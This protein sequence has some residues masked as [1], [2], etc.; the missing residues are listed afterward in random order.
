MR[1][2]RLSMIG[3]GG[4][5]ARRVY[6]TL[7]RY[8]DTAGFLLDGDV[9]AFMRANRRFWRSHGNFTGGNRVI[10]AEGR[11]TSMYKTLTY[12]AAAAALAAA[13]DAQV[14]Y[15]F[16]HSHQ[17]YDP[18]ARLLPSFSACMCL[19]VGE[20]VRSCDGE[21]DVAVDELYRSLRAP[22]DILNLRYKGVPVGEQI[23]DEILFN[24]QMASVWSVD[25]KARRAIRKALETHEAV[26]GLME[27]Y[28]IRAGVFTHTTESY[29]GIAARTLLQQQ[30]PV[31]HSFGG[32]GAFRRYN[33]LL[34]EG[35]GRLKAPGYVP[36]RLFQTLMS[37]HG[38]TLTRRAEAFMVGWNADIDSPGDAATAEK[39]V[40]TRPESFCRDVGLDPQRPCVF[41]MLHAL[42]DDPHIHEQTIFDDYYGWLMQTLEIA[43]DVTTVNWIFKEHPFIELYPD[44]IERH[45]LFRLVNHDH[46]LYLDENASF[47]S[48]SLPHIA[49]AI[50]TCAGTAALEYT[51]QG[52]P[53][54]LPVRNHYA[55][56]GLCEEPESLN[57]YID[58][59][60][61][62]Q[63]IPRPDARR[64]QQALVMFYLIN[65]LVF[66]GM[67]KGMLPYKSRREAETINTSKQLIR[68]ATRRVQASEAAPLHRAVDRLV[69]FVQET[70]GS[71]SVE[72]LHLDTEW[73]GIQADESSTRS[74]TRP[75]V[76]K[77]AP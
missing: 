17:L 51:A 61:N 24:N 37:Q 4:G 58:A 36:H 1:Q 49:H 53:G 60:R 27:K 56:H 75:G 48:A 52:V 16:E 11:L 22:G 10:L 2:K 39:K 14:V 26:L 65:G 45:A 46:I 72:A 40:Y 29:H 15:L 67:N 66:P 70:E 12:P 68:E 64:R 55:G 3:M 63:E 47:H 69:K 38:D 57:D 28:D 9:R 21:I 8:F 18:L 41:V 77:S 42:T 35:R 31:F 33:R 43:R 73:L 6:R 30:R 13:Y 34:D 74:G 7:N 62:I 59:L 50:V 23:Y 25:E 44:D 32:F 19:S 5:A 20:A 54:I 76:G 71:T